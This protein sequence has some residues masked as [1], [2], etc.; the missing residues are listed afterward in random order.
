M[1]QLQYQVNL[2]HS[3][4]QIKI[5]K[6]LAKLLKAFLSKYKIRLVK[7]KNDQNPRKLCDKNAQFS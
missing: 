6:R 1:I 5:I 4:Y 3:F 7:Q 2:C